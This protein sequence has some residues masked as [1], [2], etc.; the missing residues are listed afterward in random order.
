MWEAFLHLMP[1]QIRDK[2]VSIIE[3][4]SRL[5]IFHLSP[6]L[7]GVNTVDKVLF[8]LHQ[9]FFFFLPQRKCLAT[10]SWLLS[11][12]GLWKRTD[13]HSCSWITLFFKKCVKG[14]GSTCKALQ[15]KSMA[16]CESVCSSEN[17]LKFMETVLGNLF[18]QSELDC[19]VEV[20]VWCPHLPLAAS[21]LRTTRISLSCSWKKK[22]K[23]RLQRKKKIINWK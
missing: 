16:M 9:L 7:L 10:Q 17:A 11:S 22:K 1:R 2:V 6:L 14:C 19:P 12:W 20:T 4:H 15:I 18:S 23:K 21:L 5:W 8:C 3:Q 13:S